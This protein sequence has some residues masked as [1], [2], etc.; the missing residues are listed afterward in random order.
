MFSVSYYMAVI[1]NWMLRHAEAMPRWKGHAIIG[2]AFVLSVVVLLFTPVWMFLAYSVFVWGPVSVF[3]HA[4]D[5]VWKKRDQIT[6]HRS[7]GVYR[8]RKLLKGFRK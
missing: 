7:E 8:T 1:Y 4:F 5:S 2:V 6:R 3:A